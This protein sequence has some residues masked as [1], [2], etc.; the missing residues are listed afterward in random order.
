MFKELFDLFRRARGVAPREA[1]AR[2]TRQTFGWNLAV[3]DLG[4]VFVAQFIKREGATLRDLGRTRHGRL[5]ALKETLHLGTGPQA[6]FAVGE[7]GAAQGIDADAFSDGGQ[8]VG[9][10][11]PLPSV[12]DGPRAGNRGETQALGEGGEPV[13]PPAVLPVVG[14]CQGEMAGGSKAARHR[15]RLLLP[16]ARAAL[17]GGRVWRVQQDL[18]AHAA[19][20]KIL[21]GEVAA[22]FLGAQAT[23]G[24]Q[25]AELTPGRPV[26]RQ[27]RGGEPAGQHD[28]RAGQQARDVEDVGSRCGRDMGRPGWADQGAFA[29]DLYMARNLAGARMGPHDARDGVHIR[30]GNGPDPQKGGAVHVFLWMGA[31]GEEGEVRGGAELGE[32]GGVI[33]TF[34][35]YCESVWTLGFGSGDLQ[36]F[37]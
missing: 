12:H 18:V 15:L 27:K 13:K 10:L 25:P 1:R 19:F 2:Q 28:P 5:V 21:K 30:N 11:A 35:S 22:A 33:F 20:Q 31:P 6:L 8:Y 16:R 4:G 23:F 24:D 3:R 37:L 26:A 14:G 36:G 29:P 34:C 9:Q 32:H 7:G 17:G